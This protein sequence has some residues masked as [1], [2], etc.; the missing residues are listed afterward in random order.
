[1]SKRSKTPR[2]VILPF[3][4]LTS[5]TVAS[6]TFA[7]LKLIDPS[8]QV[9]S[10]KLE[11][12]E[13]AKRMYDY[14]LKAND[15]IPNLSPAE[16]T[17]LESE[18][19]AKDARRVLKAMDSREAYLKQAKQGLTV[20]VLLSKRI[21]DGDYKHQKGEVTLWAVIATV[22]IDT[23]VSE[24]PMILQQREVIKIPEL[25]SGVER[26]HWQ[27][28]CSLVARNIMGAIVIP[29]LREE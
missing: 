13:L 4:I 27:A 22:L 28:S 24:D 23:T 11:R 18:M 6:D 3:L 16:K 7:C 25:P 5:F 17:W 20:L 8:V 9:A 26:R 29:Y 2:L 19:N 10:G 1:M 12:Q 15:V 21:L 14:M